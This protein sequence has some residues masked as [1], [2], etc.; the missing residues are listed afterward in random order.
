MQNCVPIAAHPER[1]AD[2]QE[3]ASQVVI[4][5]EWEH[6]CRQMLDV[7]GHYGPAAQR[8]AWRLLK[9]GALSY[10]CSD[11]HATGKCHTGSA[12]AAIAR[13]YGPEIPDFIL[14]KSDEDTQE[15]GSSPG[16]TAAAEKL[17]G[18]AEVTAGNLVGS[19]AVCRPVSAS[20]LPRCSLATLLSWQSRNSVLSGRLRW[21][22]SCLRLGIDLR[23]MRP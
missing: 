23:R 16:E 7:H 20:L 5:C 4:G 10:V 6:T 8:A 9:A 2:V 13:K 17:L 15:R 21:P 18:V 19:G 22:F 1:Y 11:Y 14:G 12:Y 3:R